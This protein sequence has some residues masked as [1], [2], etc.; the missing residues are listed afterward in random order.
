M[1]SPVMTVA[2]S[3]DSTLVATE[4]ETASGKGAGDENFPVGSFLLPKHLRPHVAD[5]YAFAR[6]ADDISDNPDLAPDDKINRLD[7]FEAGLKGE[8]PDHPGLDKAYKARASLEE[9]GIGVQHGVDLLAA[10]KQDA[11]KNRYSDWADLMGY[12]ELSANP[13]GRYLLDIHG[14]TKGLYPAS[15]ALC[16]ALQVINHLQDVQKDYRDM[17]RVYVPQDW[18]GEAGL[19]VEALNR[20]SAD[21]ALRRVLDKC[22]EGVDRLLDQSRPLARHMKSKSLAME[23]AAIQALA[24]TLTK[25]LW[26]QDPLAVRVELKKPA[27]LWLAGRAALSEWGKRLVGQTPPPLQAEGHG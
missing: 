22:L 13:V 24:E 20:P 26:L 23:T 16:S 18:L 6:A 10:F 1:G 9:L 15:D 2:E 27:F 17:D 12:C 14:E 3:K 19:T 11:K 5:F 4:V 21:L 25:R 7:L 8:L